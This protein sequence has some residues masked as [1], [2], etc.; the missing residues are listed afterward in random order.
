MADRDDT[1]KRTYD[2]EMADVEKFLEET[3]DE[4]FPRP[5]PRPAPRDGYPAFGYDSDEEV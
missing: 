5:I 4:L 3:L 2:E 1:V